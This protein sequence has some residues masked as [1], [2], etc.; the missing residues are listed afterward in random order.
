MELQ[1]CRASKACRIP[2][3]GVPGDVGGVGCGVEHFQTTA[4]TLTKSGGKIFK[5]A[6][7]S[8]PMLYNIRSQ[9]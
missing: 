3:S 8:S 5:R 9:D 1:A 2:P 7:K 4:V 6:M